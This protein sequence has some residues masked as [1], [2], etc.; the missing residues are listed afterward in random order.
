MRVLWIANLLNIVLD[1]VLI[2]GLGPFPAMG[3][4]GAAIATTTGRGL[5]VIYQFYLLFRGKRRI[6]LKMDHVRVRVNLIGKLL[7]LSAGGI[8]QYLIATSSWILLVRIISEFGN[9]VIAGYTIAIRVIIFSLLP[10]Y[11]ISNAAATLVGQNLG[12]KKPERAVRAVWIT[13]VINIILM[14]I[15]GIVFILIPGPFIRFFS[16]EVNVTESGMLGLQIISFGFMAYGL[17]MVLVNSLNGAGD[18]ITP[19]K[20]NFVCFWLIEIPLAYLL[21]ITLGY[22]EQG[23]FY[24]IVFAETIM[25]VMAAWYFLKGKWKLKEV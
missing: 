2:F 11:G 17:G 10:S 19:T 25:T 18:T 23:V 13:G 12:A 7:R 24:A 6:R 4:E 21:A 9:E 22:S 15:I 14:G 8:G 5:A 3:I 1:P 20:I 16:T